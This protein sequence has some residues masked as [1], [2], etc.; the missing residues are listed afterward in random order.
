MCEPL[1]RVVHPIG[2][3]AFKAVV[4]AASFAN[5]LLHYKLAEELL[6]VKN[7]FFY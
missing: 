6:I 2:S 5:Q 3:P 4:K 7:V 1:E